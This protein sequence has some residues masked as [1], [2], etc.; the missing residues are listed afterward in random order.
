VSTPDFRG[1]FGVFRTTR[2]IEE[3]IVEPIAVVTVL[4]VFQLFSFAFLVGKQRV[5]HGVKAPAITGEAEFE[6][7]F[8][9][10]QNTVEQMVIFI[11]ALW[12]FG[13]Y[14][15]ALIGAALGLVFVISRFI[16]RKSYLSEPTTRATGFGIGALMMMILTIGGL[17]G[18]ILSWIQ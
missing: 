6:R 14:V 9:I 16:Y 2:K 7:A 3:K 5:K 11:P 17:I 10:H 1:F 8:R 12:L 13:Y 4:A 18:A 15:H